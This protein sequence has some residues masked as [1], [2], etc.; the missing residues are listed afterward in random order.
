M[1]RNEAEEQTH[2]KEKEVK[3]SLKCNPTL[4]KRERRRD[5]LMEKKEE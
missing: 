1:E 5:A 3:V 4:R 2:G